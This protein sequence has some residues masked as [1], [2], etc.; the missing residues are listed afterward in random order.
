[1]LPG[2]AAWHCCW[3][4]LSGAAFTVL[5]L[6]R[7]LIIRLQMGLGTIRLEGDISLYM[8]EYPSTWGFVSSPEN[9]PGSL[10]LMPVL[11]RPSLA[12]GWWGWFSHGTKC[13]SCVATCLPEHTNTKVHSP[14]ASVGLICHKCQVAPEVGGHEVLIPRVLYRVLH[15]AQQL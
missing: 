15:F 9:R 13:C 7:F 6:R 14:S 11:P 5:E 8:Q 12:E 1:M 4:C 2:N 3:E 10:A